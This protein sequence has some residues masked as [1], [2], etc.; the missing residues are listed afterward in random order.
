MESQQPLELD[1][2]DVVDEF[3]QDDDEEWSEELITEPEP[4]LSDADHDRVALRLAVFIAIGTLVLLLSF[5][6][7]EKLGIFG[8]GCPGNHPSIGV[9][10]AWEYRDIA[11]PSLL[12]PTPVLPKL[13]LSPQ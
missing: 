10:V 3:E 11:S 13:D 8:S 1:E 2:T 5:G 9:C 6:L 7:L 4:V 12:P